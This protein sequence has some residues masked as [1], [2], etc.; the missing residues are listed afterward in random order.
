MVAQASQLL[1]VRQAE[2]AVFYFR[3]ALYLDPSRDE[4]RILM[5]DAMAAGKDVEGARA[6]YAGVKPSAAQ[7]SL[8]RA[9][10]AWTYQRSKQGDMALKLA[11]EGYDAAPGDDEAAVTYADLL[12][13][14]DHNAEAVTI[15]NQ[16]ITR[17]GPD[18]DW[19]LLYMRGVA[20]ELTGRWPEAERDLKAALAGAPNEPE[21]LNYLGYS[22][23]DRGENLS[24]ALDMV[25]RAV[26]ENPRSGA[27][28]DSLGWAYYRLGDYR[29]AVEQLEMAVLL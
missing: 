21:L 22:W 16:V 19:R 4:A 8:A 6:A 5:G 7:Y 11:K 12:R 18:P 3:M 14:N 28:I 13:A 17:A 23:I 1:G 10:L 27:I 24:V 25:K 9:K 20:L 26:A 2:L 15:F 29:N